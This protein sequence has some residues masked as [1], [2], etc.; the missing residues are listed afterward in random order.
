MNYCGAPDAGGSRL[1]RQTVSKLSA[2]ELALFPAIV[3]RHWNAAFRMD[4]LIARLS[5]RLN[6]EQAVSAE[7]G[8]QPRHLDEVQHPPE[9]VS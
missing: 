9:I 2:D 4:L 1:Q 8:Y 6:C 3:R 7:G 5:A